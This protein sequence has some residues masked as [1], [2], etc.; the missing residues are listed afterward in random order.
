MTAG[1]GLHH[2]LRAATAGAHADLETALDW[3][4]RV[5]TR[6]GYRGLLARL[7]GFHAAYEP[8]IGRAL[9]DE[10]FFG[11]R[12]RLQALSADLRHL[13]LPTPESLP[14]PAEPGLDGPS[15]FGALYVLE[16]STLGGRVIGRHIGERHGLDGAGLV[17]YRAHGARTGAMWADFRARLETMAGDAATERAVLAAGVATFAAMR[18]W[19]CGREAEGDTDVTAN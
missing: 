13:G 9:A 6:A 5:A 18:D 4:A 10:A 19:L 14:R 12:R 1:D 17:Y 7:H 8:A 15:A 16:G 11:P 2:R 3:Q